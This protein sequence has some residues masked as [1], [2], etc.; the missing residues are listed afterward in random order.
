MCRVFGVDSSDPTWTAWILAN[1]LNGPK[2]I[3]AHPDNVI[4]RAVCN[5]AER[6]ASDITE[7]DFSAHLTPVPMTSAEFFGRIIFDLLEKQRIAQA[8]VNSKSL[9]CWIYLNS[10]LYPHS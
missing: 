8:S 1:C 4:I 6:V 2:L 7:M 10:F 9:M 3:K 5:F